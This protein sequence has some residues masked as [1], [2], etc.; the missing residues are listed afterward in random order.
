MPPGKRKPSLVEILV[1]LAIFLIFASIIGGPRHKRKAR[2]AASRPAAAQ[3]SKPGG[4][5]YFIR[6]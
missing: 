1:I 6:R 4:E 3:T 2:Q 5:R